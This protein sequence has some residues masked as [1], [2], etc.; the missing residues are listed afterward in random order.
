MTEH[1]NP[2]RSLSPSIS[3]QSVRMAE[4]SG[5]DIKPPAEPSDVLME[6]CNAWVSFIDNLIVQFKLLDTCEL[7]YSKSLTKLNKYYADIKAKPV[8]TGFELGEP[9]NAKDLKNRDK[10]STYQPGTDGAGSFGINGI[11]NI[12][13]CAKDMNHHQFDQHDAVEKAI[14]SQTIPGLTSAKKDV[15]NKLAEIKKEKESR[16]KQKLKDEKV[17]RA[18]I[19]KLTKSLDAHKTTN[20]ALQTKSED[21]WKHHS[22]IKTHIYNSRIRYYGSGNYLE[23]IK[24][25]FGT[26]ET[27]L[28]KNISSA[29]GAYTSITIAQSSVTTPILVLQ[30]SI[31][32]FQPT[33]E[34]HKYCTAKLDHTK[35]RAA[36]DGKFPGE[37][38]EMTRAIKEGNVLRE[39]RIRKNISEVY[40]ILTSTGWIHEYKERPTDDPN[41]DE[42]PLA[43][44]R[45]YNCTISALGVTSGKQATPAEFELKETY[46][47]CFSTKLRLWRYSTNSVELSE[48]WWK[49]IKNFTSSANESIAAAAVG[50]PIPVSGE[51]AKE[52]VAEP[53]SAP[54]AQ[55]SSKTVEEEPVTSREELTEA[56]EPTE[57]DTSEF[58]HDEVIPSVQASQE[59]A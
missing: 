25:S 44:I 11:I 1:L 16:L 14:K 41:A 6:R 59:V 18:H 45:L 3:S 10:D 35:M 49:A 29:I 50:A 5:S 37:D 53:A 21:P 23:T 47:G 8:Y 51:P 40:L 52:P 13:D 54:T 33:T 46:K 26:F 38:H 28:F 27:N 12:L 2:S 17:L 55:E 42:K 20:V 7:S 34:W 19:Q 9:L 15:Q 58:K 39:G 24:E 30:K 31:E 43:S 56:P 36:F 4:E 32:A 22:H 48:E 57:H